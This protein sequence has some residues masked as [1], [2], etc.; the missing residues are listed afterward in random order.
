MHE[1]I[2]YGDGVDVFEGRVVGVDPAAGPRPG[3]ILA[4]E[5]S[6]LNAGMRRV[7]ERIAALDWPCLAIDVYG[8]GI[9]GDE[10]GDNTHLMAPLLRDR[11]L[12]RRRLVAGLDAAKRH[13]AFDP[14]RLAIVGHCFG[15]LCALDLA[16]AAPSGLRAAVSFHGV[17]TPPDL[18]PQP[19]IAASVL[20][21][22]GWEDPVAPAPDVLA[23]ARELTDAGADWQLHA[24][25]HAMHAFTFEGVHMP[26]RGIAFHPDAAR[27]SWDAMKTF[28]VE[29]L[30]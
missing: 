26:E 12:L 28:L 2:E 13:P 20:L 11:A 24:H 8:K 6:G 5:W 9:R 17:L 7:A 21:L 15:G 27:R 23:I 3:V 18:G 10:L 29:R 30:V 22:H 16:R 4:H 25:G 19:P 1:I 14:D